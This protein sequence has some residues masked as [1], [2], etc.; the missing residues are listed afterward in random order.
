MFSGI[1][2]KEIRDILKDQKIE[3][4]QLVCVLDEV[5]RQYTRTIEH[6]IEL[7]IHESRYR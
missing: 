2:E 5:F 3:N 7:K 4:E 6:E 1:S